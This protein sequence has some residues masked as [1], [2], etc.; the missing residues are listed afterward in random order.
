MASG[1]ILWEIN[2]FIITQ[3]DKRYSWV[4]DKKKRLYRQAM[5]AFIST[6]LFV[7]SLTY[8]YN[9]V[10]LLNPAPY[11]LNYVLSTDVP[12]NLMFA[13]IIHLL[14]TGLWMIAYHRQMVEDLK[15]KLIHLQE[16]AL[17]P[18]HA[19]PEEASDFRKTLLVNQGKGLVPVSV[20]QVAYIFIINEM[21]LV[22]TLEGQSLT[23]DASLE[24]LEEQLSPQHFFRISRQFIVQ[25][26]AVKK[27]E[28]ESSGRLLLH[29]Q[30]LISEPVI[31]SRRRATDFRQWLDQ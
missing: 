20:E 3:M 1:F 4:N 12:V 23:L 30:P 24:Q 2:K 31:V 11:N 8:I 29:L 15:G 18:R 22:K 17:A 5:L 16:R 7:L 26:K 25:K 6:S 19:E 27:V 10:V 21:T 28:N 14:Y 13:G 9:Q